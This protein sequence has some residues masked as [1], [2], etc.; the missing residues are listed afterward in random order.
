M[1]NKQLSRSVAWAILL[2]VL[3]VI[4]LFA[5]LATKNEYVSMIFSL[6]VFISGVW[7]FSF[8]TKSIFNSFK[9]KFW[10]RVPYKVIETKIAFQMP[11]NPGYSEKFIPFFKIQYSHSGELFTKSTDDNLNLP[12]GRI[13]S[14]S[15][16]AQDYLEKVKCHKYGEFALIN[17][18][19][20]EICY[21]FSGLG[22]DNLGMLIF[23]ML[24][25]ILPVLTFLEFIVWC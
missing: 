8:S 24:L 25:V 19:K 22:R 20:P 1:E 5:A 4:L 16:A 7:L 2:A 11:E 12:I 21:L 10:D 3:D 23:S 9:S 17:P 6:F 13:F 14:T 18:K 15:Q